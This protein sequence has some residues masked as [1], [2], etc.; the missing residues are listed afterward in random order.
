MDKAA[1]FRAVALDHG[2]SEAQLSE[3]I[4]NWKQANGETTQRDNA[5]RVTPSLRPEAAVSAT[6]T[7]QALAVV[8]PE[9]PTKKWKDA[10]E[11]I[12][13]KK[14]GIITFLKREWEPFIQITGE[15]VTRDVLAA[16]DREAEAA[17]ARYVEN[18]SMPKG[19][20]ILFLREKHV[21]EVKRA[22]SGLLRM[23][24]A[25]QVNHG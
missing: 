21:N 14:R 3:A 4:E 17:L 12:L 23:D 6:T 24:Q 1:R 15:V 22:R 10:P 11:K 16:H 19:I 5:A 7:P 20:S 13:G 2:L 18:H 9:W 8:A 25:M